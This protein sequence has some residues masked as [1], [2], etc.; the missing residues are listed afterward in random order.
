MNPVAE[1]QQLRGLPAIGQRSHQRQR[2]D[3]EAFRQA[4]RQRQQADGQP[5]AEPEAE[6]PAPPALQPRAAAGRN[7]QAGAERHVDVLA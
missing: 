6:P 5:A 3:A 7:M 1:L 2:G 4:L